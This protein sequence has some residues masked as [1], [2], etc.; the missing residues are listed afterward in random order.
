MTPSVAPAPAVAL[1][2]VAALAVPAAAEPVVLTVTGAISAPDRGPV[3][4]FLDAMFARFEVEFV[5]ARGFTWSELAA[6]PQQTLTV[7]FDNWPRPVTVTGPALTEVL[8]AA[9]AA[10]GRAVTVRA[11]DG[12]APQL[13]ADEVA[14]GR[15]VLGLTVDG[16][17][18][19]VG[20]RG[21]VW[22]VYPRPETAAGEP[23][24]DE[25]STWAAFHLEV[26]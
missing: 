22:V 3:D 26:E 24:T 13:S 20:G 14:S 25:Q 23:A 15:Y 2:L 18:L 16:A 4:P 21:P 5:A 1:A 19:P 11:L 10:P 7:Q 17:A 12:Y 6:L 8:A 9:G